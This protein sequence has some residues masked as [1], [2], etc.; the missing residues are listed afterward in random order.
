M[1]TLGEQSR[2]LPDPDIPTHQ[3]CPEH[4]LLQGWCLQ[5]PWLPGRLKVVVLRAQQLHLLRAW[6]SCSGRNRGGVPGE[7]CTKEQL[8]GRPCG[9][10]CR[11]S[12][13]VF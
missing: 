6:H 2:L 1:L 11:I 13:T 3:L 8:C 9:H 10:T 7:E 12:G 5:Q 4:W